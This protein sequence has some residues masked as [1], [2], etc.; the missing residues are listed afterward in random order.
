MS[1]FKSLEE[2]LG[3]AVERVGDFFS[4]DDPKPMR[5]QDQVQVRR[6][7][8]T[9]KPR[10][11][12]VGSLGDDFVAFGGP[13]AEEPRML[14]ESEKAGRSEPTTRNTKVPPTAGEAAQPEFGEDPESGIVPLQQ[15][16]Q[17]RSSSDIRK[18]LNA[19]KQEPADQP[20]MEGVDLTVGKTRRLLRK[21]LTKRGEL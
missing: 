1:I 21:E 12:P 10:A 17:D 4:G 14:K 5:A 7:T 15:E 3:V 16:L 11:K 20:I 2:D 19:I 18:T 13:D 9:P 6:P 8:P